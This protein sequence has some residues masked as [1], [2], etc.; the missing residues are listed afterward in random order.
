MLHLDLETRSTCNLLT[1]GVYRYATDPDTQVILASYAF[2][3]GPVQRWRPGQPY[4]FDGYDGPVLAWNAQFE[5]LLWRYVLTAD[6]AWPEIPLERFECVAAQA[7]ANALPGKL[8]NA[9]KCLQVRTQ[10]DMAGHRLMMK[11]C[12][13]KTVDPLTWYE[14]PDEIDRLHDYCDDDVRAERDIHACLR[15]LSQKE[16]TYYWISEHIN[17]RGL[18]VDLPFAS[19]AIEY[20]EDEKEFFAEELSRLTDGEITTARQFQRIK[21]W[22]EPRIDDEIRA[23]M[24]VYKNGEPKQTFDGAVRQNLLTMDNESPGFLSPDVR[25]MT[26]IIDEAGKSSISKYS[27][28]CNR[29]LDGRVSGL[30]MCYGAGQTGRYS[31]TAVQVHNLK[32]DVVP[33][34]NE[35]IDAITNGDNKLVDEYLDAHYNGAIVHALAGALRPTFRAPDGYKLAW[36]DWSQ[37]EARMLPWLSGD[38]RAQRTLDIFADN[39]RNPDAP[40][41]Y[42]ITAGDVLQKR[43]EDITKDE[44]QGYGKVPV[45]SLGYGGAVGA[46]Q[47]LARAY[48]VVFEESLIKRIVKDWRAANVWACDFW[49]DLERAAKRAIHRPGREYTAGRISYIYTP[50]VLN[51]LG[52]LWCKLPSDRVLCY[53]NAKIELIMQPWGKEEP[54]ITAIKGNFRPKAGEKDWPR[55]KMWGGLCAENVTQA[56]CACLMLDSHVEIYKSQLDLVGHTHDEN[57]IQSTDGD[58]EEDAAELEYIMNEPSE[59]APDLPISADVEIGQRYKEKV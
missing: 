5:R 33:K 50:D 34:T 57:V 49:N 27:A 17:D 45:L 31:S 12:Q 26:E 51:G 42:M 55:F 56:G 53:P 40:D 25:D 35:F 47:N 8:E 4:P 16:K 11:L 48:G 43:P 14:D 22:L 18:P 46:F 52:A 54:G 30:Y 6:H 13:P 32:R 7:R 37:I 15:P 3:D 29:A 58:V 1:E 23:M 9:A 2:D 10:K 28:I 24:K 59:W 19:K 36:A 44:R 21:K 39:D 20:A 38:P 41:I